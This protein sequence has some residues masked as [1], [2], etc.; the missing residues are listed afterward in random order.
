[1]MTVRE[2]QSEMVK[3][4]LVGFQGFEEVFT[5]KKNFMIFSFKFGKWVFDIHSAAVEDE[6][7]FEV[8]FF[9]FEYFL[10]FFSEFDIENVGFLVGM[11]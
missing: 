7:V 6:E 11:Y 1:M 5:Q 10:T 8:L 9:G 2:E 4:L 3:N